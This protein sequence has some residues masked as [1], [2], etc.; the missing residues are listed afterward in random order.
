MNETSL[1]NSIFS[2]R[3]KKIDK[4]A[5]EA[6]AIQH[7]V[8]MELT[9]KAAHTEWG[10]KHNY[11]AIRSYDDFASNVAIQDYESLKGYIDRMR[12]GESDVLWRGNCRWFA[13]SSGTTNDKS[14]FIPVTADG[15]KTVHYAGG[16]DSVALYLRLNPASRLFSGKALILGGSHAPNYN[17]PNSLVGDL[18]AILIENIMPMV[19]LIRVPNKKIALLSDFEEKMDRIARTTCKSNV[20]NISGVPSWMMAVLKH[21][22]EITGKKSV[23]EVWPNLEVF[24]HGGVAFTPYR[25]QYKQLI[26]S[27][28]M[29][30]LETYNASEGFFGIQNDFADP[31]MLLMLDYGVFYEFVPFDELGSPSPKAV[32]LW[33]VEVGRNYAMLISTTCGL[34]R[35]MIGDTVRFTS[36]DPY[37]FVITG[38]TKHFIN[39]FGEELIVDNAEQ[40]LAKA[41]AETGAQVADYTAAPV[42]MDSDA[43]CRHQWLIEFS[44]RPDSLEKFVE[45]LDTTL[46]QIN[47]DYEAKRYKNITMQCLEVIPAREGLFNEWLKSKGKLGGQHKVPRLSNSRDYISELLEMNR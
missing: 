28:S 29:H 4:F 30:Y 33:D 13:K 15:L 11:S 43:Q 27:S 18:S 37:K 24:F 35:Y 14:K 39:V 8:L 32:P 20:T 17:L 1:L 36:K 2:L 10:K 44:R 21:M 45:I 12:H 16:R 5:T 6:E 22:L 3:A 40:G 46:Q 34:W 7:R 38:R 19:N 26:R 9:G 42:Y 31:S 41:C 47:S 25:E 23:D